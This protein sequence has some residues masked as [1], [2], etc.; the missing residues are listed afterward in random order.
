MT[1]ASAIVGR[2][3]QVNLYAGET[4]TSTQIGRRYGAGTGQ[5]EIVVPVTAAGSALAQVG[6]TVAVYGALPGTSGGTDAI[7][8]LVAS[9]KVIGVY[10]Q[11]AQ[12]VT[13]QT[14]GTPAL[15]ALAVSQ[16]QAQAILSYEGSGA[17]VTLVALG[18]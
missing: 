1:Q 7:T 15:V 9:A 3:A 8:E 5:V 12:A 18:R 2:Y 10:T 14:P 11:A 17:S 6:Q 13:P 4:V 16:Q